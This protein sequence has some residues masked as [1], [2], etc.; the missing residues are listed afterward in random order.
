MSAKMTLEEIEALD[1]FVHM[2]RTAMKQEDHGFGPI[3]KPFTVNLMPEAA[4][5]LLRALEIAQEM[6]AEIKSLK[7]DLEMMAQVAKDVQF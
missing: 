7:E 5:T 2:L 3:A 4:R 6:R 1:R